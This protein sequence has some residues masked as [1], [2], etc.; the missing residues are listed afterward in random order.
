MPLLFLDI[1]LT[2]VD[3]SYRKIKV[4]RFFVVHGAEANDD[5]DTIR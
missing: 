3:Q 2:N 4:A 1:T 5:G